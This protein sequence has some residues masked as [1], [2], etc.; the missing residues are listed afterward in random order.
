L[1]LALNTFARSTPS[2]LCSL[3]VP[4]WLSSIL[5]FVLTLG[6][7]G[8]I[9]ATVDPSALLASFRSAEWTWV[10]VAVLLLPLNLA[11][12]GWTWKQLLHTVL[13]RVPLKPVAGG[14]LSGIALG[15]WTPARVGEYAGR[16][17]FLPEGDRWA[18]SLTVFAQRMVDM[19]VGVFVGLVLLV[20]ALVGGALPATPAWLATAAVGGATVGL[21]A[22][23]VVAPALVHNGVQW[24]VP[25]WTGVTDRT[26]VFRRLSARRTRRVLGGTGARYLVF[27]GQLACLGA[28][29]APSAPVGLL[30]GAAGLTF[31]VKYLV[32]SLTV[33]DLGV[34]EG[35]AALFFQLFGLGA[36]A[37]VNAALL[38]F[39]INLLVPALLGAPLVA[40][41]RFSSGVEAVD[42][43][44]PAP[45]SGS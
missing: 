36:A 34:R 4:R 13:D 32:P 23:F 33:L 20:G 15:F 3:P 39:T 2:N 11:L 22:P 37:G 17:L 29:F 43:R 45:L 19:A 31:Y 6:V 40:K 8:A 38:L 42:A 14:V 30:W 44:R 12:D 27:T 10:G 7:L 28:A 5:K 1:L 24:L 21:L 35:G 9:V 41:L 26:V 18:L 16:A 25:G